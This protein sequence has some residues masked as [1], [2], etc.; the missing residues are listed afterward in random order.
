MWRRVVSAMLVTGALAGCSDGRST[1]EPQPGP[2]V[3]VSRDQVASH[4]SDESEGQEDGGRSLRAGAVYAMTNEANGNAIMAWRRDSDGRLAFVG[5]FPTGGL[6]SGGGVAPLASQGSLV[7]AGH[8]PGGDRA[9]HSNQLLFAVNAGS[10]EISVLR[11][12]KDHLSVVDK[13]SS[14]GLRPISLTVYDDLLYVLNYGSGT[15]NGFRLEKKGT[16]TPIAGSARP[17]TGGTSGDPGQVEFSSHGDVLVVTGKSLQNI[18][19]YVVGRNG[20]TTG[21][22]PNHS[23]GPS[24]LGVAFDDKNHF[25]TAEISGSVSSYRLSRDGAATVVSGSVPDFQF[26]PRWIVITENSRFA[27]VSNAGTRDISSYMVSPD[28][29]VRLLQSVAALTDAGGVPIDLA[30]TNGSRFLYVVNNE[31]GTIDGYRVGPQ[32]ELVQ[33]ANAAGLPPNSEGIAAR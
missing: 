26:S 31:L 2:N 32:G 16:L 8:A 5:R 11:V 29:S 9:K 15:I 20:Q 1:T 21:P 12:H 24:P 28:G 10:N 13:V 17:I 6:G 23:N 7:L 18:D 22:R 4:E 27:Y 3:A 30:L 25:L 19:T 33:V 14:G